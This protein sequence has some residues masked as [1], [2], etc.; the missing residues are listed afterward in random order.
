MKKKVILGIFILVIICFTTIR[1]L[2]YLEYKSYKDK[3]AVLVEKVEEYKA[4]HNKLPKS[5]EDIDFTFEMGN[6]PFYEKI[7]SL[8]YIVYFSI[9]F[10]EYFTYSSET[11]EWENTP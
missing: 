3:G 8:R 11:K 9:G 2:G 4:K 6:G 10:D 1:L 5:E 7:D